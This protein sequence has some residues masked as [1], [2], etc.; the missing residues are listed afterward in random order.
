MLFII[1][2][3]FFLLILSNDLFRFPNKITFKKLIFAQND[4]K[5]LLIYI[6][7]KIK[8]FIVNNEINKYIKMIKY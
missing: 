8:N 3:K 1:Q 6:A 4:N 7:K 2:I 5:I